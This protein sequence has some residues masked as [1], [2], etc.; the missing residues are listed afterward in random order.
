MDTDTHS[1]NLLSGDGTYIPA[2]GYGERPETAAQDVPESGAGQGGG[3]LHIAFGGEEPAAMSGDDADFGSEAADVFDNF[4][5][6]I[7]DEDSSVSTPV[8]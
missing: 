7:E 8:V 6:K 1:Q 2:A 4:G 5:N 3:D